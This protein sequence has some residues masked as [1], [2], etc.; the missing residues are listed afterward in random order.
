[1]TSVVA[2]RAA[3]AVASGAPPRWLDGLGI[4]F[5]TIATSQICHLQAPSL[6]AATRDPDEAPR[7]LALALLTTGVLNAGVG[8]TAL[9]FAGDTEE[10]ATLNWKAYDGTSFDGSGGGGA[11]AGEAVPAWALAGR[12]VVLLLPV[13]CAASSFPISAVVLSNNIAE[14]LG[15]ATTSSAAA[16]SS[17]AAGT[18][19][20]GHPQPDAQE[21]GADASGLEGGGV[22]GAGLRRGGTCGPC[23]HAGS[24]LACRM[25]AVLPPIG[26]TILVHDLSIAYDVTGIC[27][28][29][30]GLVLPAALLLKANASGRPLMGI[31]RGYL[32]RLFGTWPA[33]YASIALALVSVGLTVYNAAGA[34]TGRR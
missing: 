4:A 8:V 30:L 29:V 25:L 15:L 9:Y 28:F 34:V 12:L 3:A 33:A 24:R 27:S 14:T 23:R 6:V 7:V 1:M 2:R 21:G 31:H 20:S 26:L 16:A 5:S 22:G 10:L 19:A 32:L 17:T 13:V 11:D 18:V